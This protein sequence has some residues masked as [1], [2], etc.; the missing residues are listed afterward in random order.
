LEGLTDWY[1]K[2]AHFGRVPV[3]KKDLVV[4]DSL[5]SARAFNRKYGRRLL[6]EGGAKHV[7]IDWAQVAR[8][9]NKDGLYLDP[10]FLRAPTQKDLD[11]GHEFMWATHWDVESIVLWNK[12]GV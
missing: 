7:Y 1:A 4:V 8:E 6:S 12:K 11:F 9:S 2:Y 5:E 3:S 10:A